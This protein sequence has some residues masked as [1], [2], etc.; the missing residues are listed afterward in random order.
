MEATGFKIA[1]KT[2][3]DVALPIIWHNG[4]SE[5]AAVSAIVVRHSGKPCRRSITCGEQDVD[6]GNPVV[7]TASCPCPC[8][9]RHFSY[10]ESGCGCEDVQGNRRGAFSH[11]FRQFTLQ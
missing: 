7:A 11:F 9:A 6:P 5:T 4:R 3:T 2:F 8:Q 10:H 1:T